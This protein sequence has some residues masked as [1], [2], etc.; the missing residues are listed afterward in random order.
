MYALCAPLV[1]DSGLSTANDLLLALFVLLAV[2]ALAER[3]SRL[4]GVAVGLA[5]AVKPPAVLLLPL[6]L[7]AA[8]LV[9]A[10]IAAAVPALLQ[11][12]LLLWQAP[13]WKELEAFAEP[14]GRSDGELF[15]A[16]SL[17]YPVFPFLGSSPGVLK[18]LALLGIV[19]AAGAA[20]WAGRRLRAPQ[21]SLPHVA[22]A[23]CLPLFVVFALA[24]VPRLNYQDWYIPPLLLALAH[25]GTRSRPEARRPA[26][27]G[28]GGAVQVAAPRTATA[29]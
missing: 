28:A 10:L 25:A 11:A 8:G 15:L 13:G 20:W 17:W 7:P 4:A 19:V 9:P 24:P 18:V 16:H 26:E 14:A 12:P 27:A 23:V 2:A 22:A 6:L 21:L 5:I 3:R 29:G 1:R